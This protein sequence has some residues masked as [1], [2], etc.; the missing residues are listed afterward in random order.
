MSE[1]TE[2]K[3]ATKSIKHLVDEALELAESQN[4]EA[5]QLLAAG[6]MYILGELGSDAAQI[7][8]D[9]IRMTITAESISEAPKA[10]QDID[11]LG[12]INWNEMSRR[13]LVFRIN[14]EILHP[15]GLALGYSPDNGFSEC[16]YV[17]PDGGFKYSE[18]LMDDARDKGWVK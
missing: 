4:E 10:S 12:S 8:M 7:E 13:G 11:V 6:I 14:N 18:A 17:S 15:L 9:G 5:L 1:T 3:I 2:G 16:V